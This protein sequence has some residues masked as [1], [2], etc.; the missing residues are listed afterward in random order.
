MGATGARPTYYDFDMFQVMA[1][2]TGG[3]EAQNPTPGVQVNLV[4]KKGGNTAHG[5]FRFYGENEDLQSNNLSSSLAQELNR[6]TPLS[7]KCVASNF[8]DSC[9]NR[10][11][12]Y[13]HTGF[14]LGGPI[15]K[16]RLRGW[17]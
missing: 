14:D 10:T 16:D 4:L 5:N 2:T 9:G 12:K 8:T 7:P 13:S 11:D 15:L 6:S 1:I 17:G 3:D